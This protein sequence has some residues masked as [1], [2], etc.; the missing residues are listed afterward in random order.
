MKSFRSTT[1]ISFSL[2][3]SLL[4]SGCVVDDDGADAGLDATAEEGAETLDDGA[5]DEF[6]TYEGVI[7]NP[8]IGSAIRT[9]TTVGKLD[10]F[11]PTCGVGVGP[12][13]SYTWTAPATSTYTFTTAGSSFDTV[14]HIRP[15]N[16]SAQ[17]LACNNN[18]SVGTLQSSVTL[19]VLAGTTL[20]IVVDGA[21]SKSGSF[22]LNI[23]NSS[24][25][26]GGCNSPPTQ[27][28]A[29]PGVCMVDP[30]TGSGSC[31]YPPQ[32]VGTPCNDGAA[33]T[34]SSSC[35]NY[36]CVPDNVWCVSPPNDCYEPV[37]GCN[38]DGSCLYDPEPA[39]TPCD[40][41]DPCTTET[42]CNG[43]GSCLGVDSC[44]GPGPVDDPV[45]EDPCTQWGD[46]EDCGGGNCCVSGSN[47]QICL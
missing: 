47:C 28:H 11:T 7:S 1:F 33:C 40:D 26:P 17:T 43:S 30:L 45:P 5:E 19:D 14:L 2:T 41:G 36:S 21:K 12:D 24:P 16:D 32:W 10:E 20:I 37:G 35:V 39:G 6:R 18:A 25:C 31:H 38:Y 42:L 13:V 29:G 46:F 15:F 27:C 34:S 3:T 4:G 44:P 8:W 22:Q 23:T 9:G